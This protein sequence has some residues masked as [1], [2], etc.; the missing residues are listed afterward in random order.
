MSKRSGKVLIK[1][2]NNSEYRNSQNKKWP[3][4]VSFTTSL[5]SMLPEQGLN[6]KTF[7]GNDPIGDY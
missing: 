6:L 3:P 2:E 5:Y 1:V 4:K 7:L